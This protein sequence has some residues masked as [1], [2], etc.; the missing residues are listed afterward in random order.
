MSTT[1]KMTTEAP[2]SWESAVKSRMSGSAI[3]LGDRTKYVGASEVGKCM[4]AVALGK[5]DPVEISGKSVHAMRMGQVLEPETLDTYLN[6]VAGNNGITREDVV[7]Y[8]QVELSAGP[9]KAHL[10]AL[11]FLPGLKPVV[12]EVKSVGAN[13]FEKAAAGQ[14]S[15]IY[16]TQVKAGM[17][18]AEY[19]GTAVEDEGVLLYGLTEDVRV[20]MPVSI[21][22]P[23]D[24]EAAWIEDRAARIMQAVAEG[25]DACAALPAEEDR[26][27]CFSCPYKGGCPAMESK[28]TKRGEKKK[29][30]THGTEPSFD[31]QIKAEMLVPRIVELQAQADALKA[32]IDPLRDELK[33][34]MAA[35]GV[36]AIE[37]GGASAEVT[38]SKPRE[39]IDTRALKAEMPEVAAKFTKVGEPTVSLK[40]TAAK[41]EQE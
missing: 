22:K 12:T 2:V 38:T 7:F 4:R 37:A 13:T 1:I 32:E 20:F 15:P 25:P 3:G 30:K 11:V 28:A 27:F 5:V 33:S 34:L 21:P 39:S 10:D 6:W 18:L 26:G 24:E 36:V 35:E 19:A 9:L 40:I 31:L 29:A 14:I 8:P 23:T 17:L 16:E 41:G